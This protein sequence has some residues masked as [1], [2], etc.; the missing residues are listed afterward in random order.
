MAVCAQ[1]DPLM[2]GLD[3]GVQVD[4]FAAAVPAKKSTEVIDPL[5]A[6]LP[7]AIRERASKGPLGLGDAIRQSVQIGNWELCSSLVQQLVARN[8]PTNELS[9]IAERITS[10]KLLTLRVSP[11]LTKEQ[12]EAIAKLQ[13]ANQEV[14]LDP[15]RLAPLLKDLASGDEATR[16]AAESGIA[17]GDQVAL[18]ALIGELLQP[19]AQ[20]P[21]DVLVRQLKRF[22]EDGIKSVEAAAIDGNGRMRAQEALLQ[23]HPAS[24]W[25]HWLA[26]AFNEAVE[27]AERENATR[28]FAGRGLPQR[29]QAIS[30]LN[31]DLLQSLDGWQRTLDREE[32]YL[33]SWIVSANHGIEVR[34]E[35]ARAV[36]ARRAALVARRLLECGHLTHEI[37]RMAFATILGANVAVDPEFGVANDSLEWLAQAYR[38][39]HENLPAFLEGILQQ[40]QR[41]GLPEAKIGSLRLMGHTSDAAL[42]LSKGELPTPLMMVVDDP[43]P[44]VRYEAIVA[45]GR[46][47]LG[48]QRDFI[49]RSHL[50]RRIRE[51]ARLTSAPSVLLVEPSAATAAYL[52]KH[53]QDLGHFVRWERSCGAA[54]ELIDVQPDFE[55]VVLSSR[56]ADA[57]PIEM[58]DRIRQRPT[59]RQLPV[60]VVGSAPWQR[61]MGRQASDED[62][63]TL[64]L[65][66]MDK[67]E[68]LRLAHERLLGNTNSRSYDAVAYLVEPRDKFATDMRSWLNRAGYQVQRFKNFDDA[69]SEISLSKK[70]DLMVVAS[71]V[72][73]APPMEFV[74][75]VR[76][77]SFAAVCP[78]MI[79]GP[80][81]GD[82]V[83]EVVIPES[84]DA[85]T[86]WVTELRTPASVQEWRDR[87]LGQSYQYPLQ[88]LDRERL[89]VAAQSLLR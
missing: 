88:P 1:D 23:L 89:R 19:Q 50:Q 73:G 86:R 24:G 55:F 14:A 51:A 67:Y 20:V 58:I 83:L 17:R 25:R 28:K 5:E 6:A 35:G 65:P 26:L 66:R 15:Q 77:L 43:S 32:V 31:K 44:A 52:S 46:L 53:L 60:L 68:G 63:T 87:L 38:I 64:W 21:F 16:R 11:R 45:A 75:R 48:T 37:E 84:W 80:N 62:S 71:D 10:P 59:G 27:P 30:I 9:M 33:P 42:V 79:L 78:A 41:I 4:S 69:Y 54:L 74:K 40:A 85:P 36:A 61:G 47:A 29:E 49:G 2:S 81:P 72:T 18:R 8:V 13:K 57:G 82:P 3:N 12:R 39:P 76:H 56:P 22:G 34:Q 7:R 70:I